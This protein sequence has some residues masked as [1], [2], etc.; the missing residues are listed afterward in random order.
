MPERTPIAGMEMAVGTDRGSPA[1]PDVGPVESADAPLWAVGGASTTPAAAGLGAGAD[2]WSTSPTPR[3]ATPARA[4]PA[5]RETPHQR[6]PPGRVRR[7]HDTESVLISGDPAVPGRRDQR[8]AS[9][10]AV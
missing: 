9:R 8:V 2:F 4:A 6:V 10:R 1:A 3:T 7:R 5:A